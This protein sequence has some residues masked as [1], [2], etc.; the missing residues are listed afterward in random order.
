M[1]ELLLQM[2]LGQVSPPPADLSPQMREIMAR[3]EVFYVAT[4]RA[5]FFCTGWLTLFVGA[6]WLHLITVLHSVRRLEPA[7]PAASTAGKIL[8]V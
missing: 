1:F 3:Q 7:S 6:A 4:V 5:V 8:G 2:L